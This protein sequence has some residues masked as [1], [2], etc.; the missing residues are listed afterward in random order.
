MI[1]T[2]APERFTMLPYRPVLQ[3][4]AIVEQGLL[5]FVEHRAILGMGRAGRGVAIDEAIGR[6]RDHYRD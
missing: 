1:D 4:H 6:R 3:V 5:L 2:S